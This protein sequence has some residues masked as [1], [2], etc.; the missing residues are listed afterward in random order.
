M[1]ALY[2]IFGNSSTVGNLLPS[3]KEVWTNIAND[4]LNPGILNKKILE[5]KVKA[6]AIGEFGVVS[7]DEI[8][9]T[10]VSLD[11]RK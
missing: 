7:H 8:F 2:F 1:D 4:I 11:K 6:A 10:L 5:L 3:N 9:K